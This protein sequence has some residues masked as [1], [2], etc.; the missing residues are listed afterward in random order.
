MFADLFDEGDDD[1][2]GTGTAAVGGAAIKIPKPP[3]ARSDGGFVGLQNQLSI[4][5]YDFSP[6]QVF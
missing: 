3:A 4:A 6:C 5:Q 1:A 2:Q